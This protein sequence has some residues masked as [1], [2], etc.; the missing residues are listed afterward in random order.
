[1]M[2]IKQNHK[3]LHKIV[4]Q[5]KKIDHTIQVATLHK[6]RCKLVKLAEM[7]FTSVSF[8][9]KTQANRTATNNHKVSELYLQVKQN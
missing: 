1:M 7:H 4:P 3:K 5:H 8:S 9:Q 2:V 6:G